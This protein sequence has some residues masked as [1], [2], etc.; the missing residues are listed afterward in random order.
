MKCCYEEKKTETL[1]L[2]SDFWCL[3][4]DFMK[5]ELKSCVCPT[6]I[7]WLLSET[8]GNQLVAG[9]HK[10]IDHVICSHV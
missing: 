5:C 2:H 9:R 7:T 3:T 6:A 10:L 4:D 8:L 1:I